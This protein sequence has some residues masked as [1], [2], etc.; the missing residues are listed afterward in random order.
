MMSREYDPRADG[1]DIALLDQVM[2]MGKHTC[3]T[4][5]ETH[6][7]SKTF[8]KRVDNYDKVRGEMHDPKSVSSAGPFGTCST[9]ILAK[10][11]L[12]PELKG[13]SRTF[14]GIRDLLEELHVE[15]LSAQLYGNIVGRGDAMG[16]RQT[17]YFA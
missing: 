12:R 8:K 9:G 10:A 13:H 4:F 5:D 17:V 11:E 16:L 7:A 2:S 1:M 6:A 14:Q 3:K 15:S